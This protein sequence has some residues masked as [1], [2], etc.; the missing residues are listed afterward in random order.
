MRP[1]ARFCPVEFAV[2]EPLLQGGS[3]PVV[4][5]V[6]EP[7]LQGGSGPV[8]IA[9]RES[10]LQGGSGPVV[11]AVRES[12]LQGG[13]GPVVIA[14]RESLLQG[15]SGPVVIA[16]R[17]SLLQGGSGPVVIAVRESLL[18]GDCE[19]VGARLGARICPVVIA[20]PEALLRSMRTAYCSSSRISAERGSSNSD[21]PTS[22]RF[23]LTTSV[24]CF[25]SPMRSAKR[26]V[27]SV[28]G[29]SSRLSTTMIVLSSS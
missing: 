5:A 21:S 25:A 18:Q 17:E 13:S 6:R 10:L 20:L 19:A 3:G 15:G 29:S 11:I 7:L 23:P 22:K 27:S 28:T 1:G 26:A 16:V 4:I 24:P 12:L 2:R 8:V 9:V 14:A